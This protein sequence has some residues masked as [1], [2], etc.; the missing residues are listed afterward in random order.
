MARQKL[1]KRIL[2]S[3]AAISFMTGFAAFYIKCLRWSVSWRRDYHPEAERYIAGSD[4]FIACFWHGRMLMMSAAWPSKPETLHLLISQHRDGRMISEAVQ[5]LGYSVIE[6]SSRRGG[7]QAFLEMARVL[8][9]GKPVVVT[10]DGPRGPRMR[11][12]PGALKAA[13]L[14]GAPIVPIAGST[15]SR[16]ELGTWDRFLVPKLFSRGVLVA[17]APVFI[18]RDLD[19][20]ALE[21]ARI[22]LERRLIALSDA[23]DAMVGQE[24]IAPDPLE[25]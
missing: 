9:E 10:P 14:S 7:L 2:K 13:Q 17:D 5:R 1:S 15:S 24:A 23:A 19:D 18:G 3:R 11:V 20:E 16:W 6:G 25:A 22:E 21:A 12:K 8:K 4:A